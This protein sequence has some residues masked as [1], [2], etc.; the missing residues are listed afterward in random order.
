MTQLNADIIIKN[1]HVIDP[2]QNI[3]G[4]TDV[5]ISDGKI[6]CVGDSSNYDS[7]DIINAEGKIVTPG[8]IDFH[9]HFFLPGCDFS[10]VPDVVSFCNGITTVVDAGSA[11]TATYDGLRAYEAT[12][13]TKIKNLLNVSPTGLG[14]LRYHENV[15]P[16]HWNR[17]KIKEIYNK[18][19]DELVG[20]K[21]RQS[22]IVVGE[23]G[24]S[25]LA[26][27]VKF[28]EELNCRVVVHV[29]APPC[30]QYKIADMLRTNDVFCHVYQG[31]GYTIIDSNGKVHPNIK[32]AK[33]RGVLF[34][35]SN[36]WGHFSF[37]V[38]EKAIEDGFVPDILSTDITTL[39]LYKGYVFSLPAL[40][41][42][43][44]YL[45]FKLF[46]VIKMVTETPAKAMYMENKIGCLKPEA[47]AD[48]AIFKLV[49]DKIKFK[50]TNGVI[51]YGDKKLIPQLTIQNGI[52][53]YQ[54]LDF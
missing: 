46:D 24:L 1:G 11:G 10:V 5:V 14:T 28:A 22:A 36:G 2:A 9:G 16:K 23:M 13:Q 32:E 8:L 26:E 4:V 33:N 15:D 27:A 38:A 35:A 25:P 50:D 30:E 42:K 21:I 43:Y 39:S 48:V 54:S 18:H 40:I 53:M 37:E 3:N 31:T 41:S 12:V 47:D 19:R 51:R 17:G 49:D 20:L 45:G 29:T 44:L 7:Q 6:I 34:D 52:K